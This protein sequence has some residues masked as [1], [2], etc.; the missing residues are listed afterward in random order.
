MLLLTLFLGCGFPWIS[1]SGLLLHY[2]LGHSK[3]NTHYWQF[4]KNR[5]EPYEALK[6]TGFF[7]EHTL[8][9][10]LVRCNNCNSSIRLD[11]YTVHIDICINGRSDRVRSFFSN[12]PIEFEY[13]TDISC[14]N[15]QCP[16][17]VYKTFGNFYDHII[18]SHKGIEPIA[19]AEGPKILK[20]DAKSNTSVANATSTAKDLEPVLPAAKSSS[21][22]LIS[23]PCCNFTFSMNSSNPDLK[24][25]FKHS[26]FVLK[27]DESKRLLKSAIEMLERGSF[28]AH[29]GS[30]CPIPGCNKAKRDEDNY[31][32]HFLTKH[33]DQTVISY[34]APRLS[35]SD[36]STIK[37]HLNSRLLK[38]F[39]TLRQL[40][41]TQEPDVIDLDADDQAGVYTFSIYTRGI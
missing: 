24:V 21:G 8:C 7:V 10:S 19:Q 35:E 3:V 20:V 41:A 29:I 38:L 32:Q 37:F 40:Q 16:D 5:K 18:K 27:K 36:C 9:N 31:M 15:K 30:Y 12:L 11:Y 13:I 39:N 1:E 2:A 17:T 14:G 22:R 26:S 34:L 4:C 6:K 28:P 23:C 25:F 33:S